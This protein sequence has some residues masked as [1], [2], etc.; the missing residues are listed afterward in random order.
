MDLDLAGSGVARP[1][2]W[3][4]GT[5]PSAGLRLAWHP[6]PPRQGSVWGVET[7]ELRLKT[8]SERVF[9]CHWCAQA[10][11]HGKTVTYLHGDST[12]SQIATLAGKSRSLGL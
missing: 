5:K 8:A 10:K 4:P 9:M 12:A 11:R 6:W 3:P 1:L 7:R 2:G